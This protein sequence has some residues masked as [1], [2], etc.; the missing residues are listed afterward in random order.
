MKDLEEKWNNLITK[1]EK[2]FDDEINR[3][4]NFNDELMCAS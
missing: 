1:L 2:Q 4:S 3:S